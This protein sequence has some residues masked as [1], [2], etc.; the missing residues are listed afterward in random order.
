MLRNNRKWKYIGM[1]LKKNSASVT[2][3]E[4][5]MEINQTLQ[6]IFDFNSLVPERCGNNIKIVMMTSSNGC[7]FCVTGHLSGEFTGEFPSQRPVAQSFDVFFDLRP[8][9]RLS[10]QLWDWWFQMPS[11]LLWCYCN[12]MFMTTS[13][14]I[15][16]RWMP[17]T[18]LMISQHWFR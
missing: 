10:K 15:A 12:E 4:F 18:P 11:C 6:H 1:F 8:N 3:V 5:L 7:I 17:E 14:N 13:C 9:I 16:L 2:S